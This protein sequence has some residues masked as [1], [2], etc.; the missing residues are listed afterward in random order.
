MCKA[1]PCSYENCFNVDSLQMWHA[2]MGHSIF[3][4]LLSEFV[5]GMKI[6]DSKIVFRSF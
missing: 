5:E 4:K 1:F 3:L 6:G 2:K